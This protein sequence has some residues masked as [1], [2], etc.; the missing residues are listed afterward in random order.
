M[1]HPDSVGA[2]EAASVPPFFSTPSGGADR[3]PDV[4]PASARV[5]MHL[6]RQFGR[7]GTQG[8]TK[9]TQLAEVGKERVAA[10][11]DDVADVVRSIADRSRDQYGPVVGDAIGKAA[12]SVT[13]LAEALRERTVEGLAG[14]ARRVLSTNI[15]TAIGTAAAL[16]FVAARIGKGGTGHEQNSAEQADSDPQRSLYAP[17]FDGA[18][19]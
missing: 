17:S 9:A 15:G 12:T 6:R 4:S 18:I 3:R 14:D 10:R 16:G 7:L 5:A 8:A 2:P 1:P 19:A 11:L 13:S